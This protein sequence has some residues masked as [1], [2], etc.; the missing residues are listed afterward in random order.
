LPIHLHRAER[1]RDSG[2]TQYDLWVIRILG[3]VAAVSFIA[4]LVMILKA[5]FVF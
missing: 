3:S 5:F 2:V 1:E 4:R